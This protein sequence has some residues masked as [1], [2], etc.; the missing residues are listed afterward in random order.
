MSSKI[1]NKTI[2]GRDHSRGALLKSI[3]LRMGFSQEKIAQHMDLSFSAWSRHENGIAHRFKPKN[4]AALQWL[5]DS[6]GI[7]LPENLE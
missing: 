5:C 4:R 2:A 7:S 3:R 1:K 6:Q